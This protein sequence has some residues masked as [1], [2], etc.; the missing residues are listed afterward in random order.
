MNVVPQLPAAHGAPPP[1]AAGAAAAVPPQAPV[2]RAPSMFTELYSNPAADAHAG[3]Y[4]PVL[5]IFTAEPAA[6]QRTPAEST[7]HWTTQVTD[8]SKPTSCWELMI[9]R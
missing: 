7:Q 9:A 1:P 8:F 3:V 5:A 4:G 6:G 2:P